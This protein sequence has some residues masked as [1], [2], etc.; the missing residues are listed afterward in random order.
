MPVLKAKSKALVS[1]TY[2]AYIT[3]VSI[4]L[5]FLR[6]A[7]N[8]VCFCKIHSFMKVKTIRI[9]YFTITGNKN[10]LQIKVETMFKEFHSLLMGNNEEKLD[11]YLEKYGTSEIAVRN[12]LINFLHVL[13]L[14][15]SKLLLQ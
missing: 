4:L 7:D 14:S 1:S 12:G 8:P 9:I 6:K 3:G 10:S 2:K 13:L 5:K 15:L 11:E